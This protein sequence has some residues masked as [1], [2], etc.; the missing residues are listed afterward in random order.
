[1]MR[2]F[3]IMELAQ[4]FSIMSVRWTV[5]LLVRQTNG[6]FILLNYRI[7]LYNNFRS[8]K[9]MTKVLCPVHLYGQLA[10]SNF[11]RHLLTEHGVLEELESKL[12]NIGEKNVKSVKGKRNY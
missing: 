2:W 3:K 1:M 12:T 11:G 8:F 4:A 6:N 7:F 5:I 9:G 10:S